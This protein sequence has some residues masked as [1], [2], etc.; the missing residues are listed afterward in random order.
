MSNP[1]FKL[2]NNWNMESVVWKNS[3]NDSNSKDYDTNLNN[4]IK[5]LYAKVI[6]LNY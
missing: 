3:K 5:N 6:R 4:Y 1:L 2:K